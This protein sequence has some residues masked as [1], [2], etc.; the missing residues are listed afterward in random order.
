MLVLEQEDSPDGVRDVY[1]FLAGGTFDAVDFPICHM[2]FSFGWMMIWDPDMARMVIE[3]EKNSQGD[4][5]FH[6]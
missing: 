2:V 4:R 6:R 1:G 5:E 3:A